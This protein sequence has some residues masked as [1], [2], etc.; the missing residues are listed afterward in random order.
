MASAP[1]IEIIGDVLPP[2][3]STWNLTAEQQPFPLP[4]WLVLPFAL[5]PRWLVGDWDVLH[6]RPPGWSLGIQ[7]HQV[8][9]LGGTGRGSLFRIFC[10]SAHYREKEVAQ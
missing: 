1:C 4:R 6:R 10:S 7:A 9:D 5:G 2:T 3:C 8:M